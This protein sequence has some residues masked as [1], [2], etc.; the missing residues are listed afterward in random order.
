VQ[1]SPPPDRPPLSPPVPDAAP[2][3]QPQRAGVR[4]RPSVVA[5]LTGATLALLVQ[6]TLIG[7]GHYIWEEGSGENLIFTLVLVSALCMPLLGLRVRGVARITLFCLPAIALMYISH[8]TAAFRPTEYGTLSWL[9]ILSDTM[10]FVLSV[11]V[12][13]RDDVVRSFI[14]WGAI[15]AVVGGLASL[16]ENAQLGGHFGYDPLLREE[17]TG[18]PASGAYLGIGRA[19]AMAAAPTIVYCLSEMAVSLPLFINLGGVLFATLVMTV[20]GGRSPAL[21]LL[22][23]I[24]AGLTMR[25]TRISR[26]RQAMLLAV[27][28]VLGLLAATSPLARK[29]ATSQ[30]LAEMAAG[31]DTSTSS[32][33]EAKLQAL[34]LIAQSPLIGQGSGTFDALSGSRLVYPHDLFLELAADY[35]LPVSL[36]GLLAYLW[37]MRAYYRRLRSDSMQRL[38][39]DMHSHIS[40]FLLLVFWASQIPFMGLNSSTTLFAVAGLCVGVISRPRHAV[41][42]ATGR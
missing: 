10:I 15:I 37:L 13:Q 40:L 7:V 32:R 20:G 30:R 14:W 36:P 28:V 27:L 11:L 23:M 2:A 39:P 21:G 26:R 1:L 31:R 4:Q 18:G 8:T 24:L 38:S 19:L 12:G 16:R 41:P 33:W 29:L 6:N 17:G 9:M 42:E 5:M 3:W 34:R 35:G 25:V 22:L